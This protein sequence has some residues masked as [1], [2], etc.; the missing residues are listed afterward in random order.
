MIRILMF[1]SAICI[2]A[3]ST[4]ADDMFSGR[5]EQGGLVVGSVPPGTAITFEGAKVP[6]T[7]DGTFLLGI[8][9]DAPAKIE[10]HLT[11]PDGARTTR[12]LAVAKRAWDI[13]RVDGVPQQLVTPDP[14]LLAKITSENKLMLAAYM[15]L[16]P[17]PLFRT[18]FIRPAEGRISGV[19][20]S[21][22]I[23]NGTPMAPH[24]GLDI[25][26]P[27]GTPIHAA[28]DGIVALSHAMMVLTGNT[29]IL[30]HGYGLET[31]Y[32]HMSKLLVKAGDHVKQGDV[33][34]EVGMTGRV[35][36]PHLHFSATWFNTRLDPE[37]LLAVLPVSK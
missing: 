30:N 2:S 29:I 36:G 16:E 21:Q 34:G 8:G 28:A 6:V 25:A 35:T 4:A 24:T 1:L 37:T 15:T 5:I 20:G 9:R 26:A 11:A 19:F 13:D 17:T 3:V 18:G 27:T 31:I 10:I 23:L 33:I 32:M 7:D 12:T 14:E 22:R